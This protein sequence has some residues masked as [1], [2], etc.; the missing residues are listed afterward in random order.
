MLKKLGYQ[1]VSCVADG[2]EAIHATDHREI[3][4]VLMDIQM[5]RMDGY[6]AT[7]MIREKKANQSHPWIIAITAGAQREDS[8]KAYAAG[9]NDFIT[10]PIQ[11]QQLESVLNKAMLG[12]LT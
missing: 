1:N 9:M 3:D 2:H 4:I 7:R 8:D 11:L 6:T 12:G 5:D 10:K